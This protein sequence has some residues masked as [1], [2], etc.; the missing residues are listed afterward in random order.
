MEKKVGEEMKSVMSEAKEWFSLEVEYLKLTAA[1]KLSMIVSMTILGVFALILF[2]VVMIVLAFAL[3]DL[4]C[5][6]MPH[7]LAC[8]TV[9]GILL[10]IIA[11]LVLLRKPIFVNPVT[12]LISKMFLAPKKDEKE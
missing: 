8:V 12:K 11:L 10:F 2:F 3:V 1:E 7:S 4:F 6:M 5:L 9:G